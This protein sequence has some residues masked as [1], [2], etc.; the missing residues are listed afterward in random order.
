MTWN[1]CSIPAFFFQ[2]CWIEKNKKYA[3]TAPDHLTAPALGYTAAGGGQQ[4]GTTL[5][6][7]LSVW[8]KKGYRRGYVEG[9]A[10]QNLL[11]TR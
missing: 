5:G 9:G 8:L 10:L 2:Q 7:N 4:S 6:M 11:C 1:C 3:A